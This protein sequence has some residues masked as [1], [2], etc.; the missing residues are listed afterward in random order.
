MNPTEKGKNK[1]E[2]L[3]KIKAIIERGDHIDINRLKEII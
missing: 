1:E 3:I 2:E